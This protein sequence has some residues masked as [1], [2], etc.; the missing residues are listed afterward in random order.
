LDSLL[1]ALEKLPD[2]MVATKTWE[3]KGEALLGGT[4][5]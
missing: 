2:E 5:H 1:A 3:A 4:P